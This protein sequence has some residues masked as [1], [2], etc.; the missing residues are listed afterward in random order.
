MAKGVKTGG[1][2]KGS[3]NKLTASIKDAFRQAFEQRG[4]VQALVAWADKEGNETAFYNLIGRLVP[5]EM[6][7]P[8]GGPLTITIV[9]K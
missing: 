6:T 2:R 7:G 9:R 1:R 8:E 3:T 4:G 5:T